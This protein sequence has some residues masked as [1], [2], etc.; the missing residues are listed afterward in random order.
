MNDHI[1]LIITLISLIAFATIVEVMIKKNKMKR[2]DTYSYKAVF[3]VSFRWLLWAFL[4]SLIIYF[5]SGSIEAAL[6][7]GAFLFAC[8]L[9]GCLKALFIEHNIKQRGGEKQ[10]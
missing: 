9:A 8:I 3:Q 7:L 5:F 4:F 6:T 2:A 1:F 10:N